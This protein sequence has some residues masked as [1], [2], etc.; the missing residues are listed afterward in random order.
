MA[1]NQQMGQRGLVKY[2]KKLLRN[3]VVS[4]NG[5]TYKRMV[6]LE[7]RLN[8]KTGQANNYKEENDN[9]KSL[10]WLKKVMN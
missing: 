5:S 10:S 9:V 4:E 7:T 3:G 6:E 1:K 2:Y 8:N